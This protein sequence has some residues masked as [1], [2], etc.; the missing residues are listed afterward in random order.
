MKQIR[1][2][3]SKSSTGVDFFSTVACGTSS[4][5]STGTVA[6]GAEL[7]SLTVTTLTVDQKS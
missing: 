3:P 4:R 1:N 7:G 5:T 2:E 6:G